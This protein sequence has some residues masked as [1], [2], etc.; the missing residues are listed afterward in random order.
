MRPGYHKADDRHTEPADHR[1]ALGANV[2][3]TG[4]GGDREGKPGEE[5]IGGIVK[6]KA[7]A[8]A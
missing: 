5:E 8:V 4:M 7:P 6:R 2:E 1:L 3:Q